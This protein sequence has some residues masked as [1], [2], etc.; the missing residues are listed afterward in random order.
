MAVPRVRRVSAKNGQ[1]YR[2]GR[3]INLTVKNS[4]HTNLRD[5]LL[6]DE[7]VRIGK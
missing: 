2:A 5:A 4:G 3:V 6:T 7:K 1:D